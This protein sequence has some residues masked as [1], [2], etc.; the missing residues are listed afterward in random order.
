MK[1]DVTKL[2]KVIITV[3]TTGGL[4]GKEANP[5]LPE[6]PKEIVQAM[7]DCYNAG[8][9]IAH[10]HVRDPQGITTSSLDKYHEVLHGITDT[11]R[12]MITQV[13]NGIG[14][15][16]V[17]G[18]NRP[19]LGFT[20]E[21]R[22]ALLNLT[23]RPDMLTVNAGTFHFQHKFTEFLFDNS[24]AWNTQFIKGCN[25]RGIQNEF[26][27][28]DLSHIANIMKLVDAGVVTGPLHFS[29]VI[30]I[31]GGIP[32]SPQNLMTMID[33]LPE[34]SS[35][36]V[37]CIGRYQLPLSMMVLAMGGNIRVGTEDNVYYHQG[38]LAVSN[39]QLVERAVRIARELGREIA[40][41]EEARA[42]MQ[43]STAQ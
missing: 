41:P 15:R 28:Y 21:E 6:Q 12:A 22:M 24:K 9:S 19:G 10:L 34:G 35:W 1:P 30:G 18:P 2:D 39:A 42:M 16:Y 7:H 11:C 37:V 3:A 26:E 17:D 33:A 27:V 25:E 38:V 23:P 14:V 40:T 20:Q 5:A 4:H 31:D 43:M 29:L 32:A 36:Q 8:A 13:G